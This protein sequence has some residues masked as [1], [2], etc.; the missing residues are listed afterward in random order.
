MKRSTAKT[1]NNGEETVGK[2]GR[3]RA[4][5]WRREASGRCPHGDV[6]H[7]APPSPPPSSLLPSR[8]RFLFF[9]ASRMN[10][11]SPL[12]LNPFATSFARG[13]SRA[14]K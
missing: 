10:D 5:P 9:F 12:R 6:R 8:R 1:M 11:V 4:R 3:K 14:K 7:R 13:L 2:G